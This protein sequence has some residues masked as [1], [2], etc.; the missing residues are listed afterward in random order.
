[1]IWWLG[2]GAWGSSMRK[3]TEAR[4]SANVEGFLMER[5]RRDDG[6]GRFPA[7]GADSTRGRL[8]LR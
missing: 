4:I 6:G 1:M 2:T 7:S 8:R 5:V 3:E